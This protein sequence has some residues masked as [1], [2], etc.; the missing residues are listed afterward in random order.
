MK[1]KSMKDNINLQDFIQNCIH[2]KTVFSSFL[3]I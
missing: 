1:D 3:Y 2:M